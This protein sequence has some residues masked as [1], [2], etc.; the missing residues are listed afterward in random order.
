MTF[1]DDFCRINFLTGNRD[2]ACKRLGIEWPPPEVISIEGFRWK[3][4]NYSKLTDKQ[5]E[6]MT[7]VVRGAEYK[8]VEGPA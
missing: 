4:I 2:I 3:R 1:D 5:R 7:H 6:G 8:S